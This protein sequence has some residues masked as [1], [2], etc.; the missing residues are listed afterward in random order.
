MKKEKESWLEIADNAMLF[1]ACAVIAVFALIGVLST[2][3]PC[4]CPS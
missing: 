1:V 2:V 3:M 4:G